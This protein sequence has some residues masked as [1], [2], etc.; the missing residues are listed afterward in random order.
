M[1]KYVFNIAPYIA[2]ILL[3]LT[4]LGKIQA[5]MI[6]GIILAMIC[7]IQRKEA[8]IIFALILSAVLG[9]TFR[10]FNIGI[11]GS[12]I[13]LLIAFFLL[14]K[15]LY[16]IKKK[17][18]T[19]IYTGAIV[20]IVIF[21]LLYGG[22]SSE[23][24]K[25]FTALL[26]TITTSMLA[27]Y[28]IAMFKNINLSKI[29]IIYLLS[30]IFF[31]AFAFDFY[32]YTRTLNLFDFESF[33]A[34][35][36]DNGELGL[37]YIVYHTPGM[38]GCYSIAFYL[39]DK[40]KLTGINDFLILATALWLI[41][42]SGARQAM[43]CYFIIIAA[44]IMIKNDKLQIRNICLTIVLCI[45]GYIFLSSLEVESIQKVFDTT[46]TAEERLNRGYDFT[47]KTI[48][49]NFVMGVGFGNFHDP[50]TNQRYAHNIILEILS[51][52]GCLGLILML[53]I[54]LIFFVRNKFSLFKRT[55]SNH[56][57]FIIFIPYFIKSMVSDDFSQNIILFIIIFTLFNKITHKKINRNEQYTTY[58]N[59]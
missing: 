36:V 5:I 59:S 45:A 17:P 32:G 42:V 52:Q 53:I 7:F 51:E 35:M 43:I 28:P 25:K 24:C 33:R 55:I 14:Y 41:L 18:S 16:I 38:F 48:R 47:F 44:W 37:P 9:E 50:M 39:S 49:E 22:M 46:N 8:G 23:G 11:P 1:Q 27:F 20:L 21:S 58:S 57:A 40:K 10:G 54:L 3:A 4:M 19:I 2:P 34:S 26:I 12:I 30:G 15:D 13:S 56:Y 29:A 6:L 31:I